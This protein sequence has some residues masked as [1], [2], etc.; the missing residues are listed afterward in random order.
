MIRRSS[1]LSGS[2]GYFLSSAIEPAVSAR[3]LSAVP[4]GIAL[5]ACESI[6]KVRQRQDGGAAEALP[7]LRQPVIRDR[8]IFMVLPVMP[9]VV[10]RQ[11]CR[12]P[13]GQGKTLR[14]VRS[15]MLQP[16]PE[17]KRH[18]EGRSQTGIPQQSAPPQS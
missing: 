7:R 15:L 18:H 5:G 1:G 4:E 10:R 14:V 6:D 8:R 9:G 13:P 17:T 3:I 2:T 11:Q 16:Q 12:L